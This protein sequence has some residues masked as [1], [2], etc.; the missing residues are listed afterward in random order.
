MFRFDSQDIKSSVESKK[1][2][3]VWQ[4][5]TCPTVASDLYPNEKPS[6]KHLP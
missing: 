1:Q 5:M 6:Y 2:F 4:R 3:A